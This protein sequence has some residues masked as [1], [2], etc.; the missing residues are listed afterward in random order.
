MTHEV[1]LDIP[2]IYKHEFTIFLHNI[3]NFKNVDIQYR[4]Y[5]QSNNKVSYFLDPDGWVSER[6]RTTHIK[7]VF[8]NIN[9]AILFK[10]QFSRTDF[11]DENERFTFKWIQ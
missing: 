6:T 2:Y 7:L 10:L 9:D 1:V 3:M 11:M 5:Y 4:R 8:S